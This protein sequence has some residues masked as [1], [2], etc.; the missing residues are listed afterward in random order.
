MEAIN[1]TDRAARRDRD[2]GGVVVGY[3]EDY[4]AASDAV[5]QLARAGAPVEHQ[6]NVGEG[7]QY[8]E[9]V[10]AKRTL[11]RSIVDGTIS[12]AA[13]GLLTGFFLAWL[14]WL[15][16]SVDRGSPVLIAFLFGAAIGALIS[17]VWHLFRLN[18]TRVSVVSLRASR[19][20]VEADDP[21][22]AAQ[23]AQHL[24]GRS[25]PQA[26]EAR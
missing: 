8:V 19:Y 4:A 23:A 16:P 10:V 15:D 6:A 22:F 26:N 9:D 7:M 5:D 20:R 17:V 11:G 13:V 18:G 1:L 3:F 21:V 25:A 2:A 24:A 14:E 12:G